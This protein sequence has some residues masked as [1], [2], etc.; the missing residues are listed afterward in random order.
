[1]GLTP[2]NFTQILQSTSTPQKM[3]EELVRSV[4]PSE[5]EET[6]IAFEK[7][8]VKSYKSINDQIAK[9]NAEILALQ[10]RQ[11]RLSQ[12][13]KV[14]RISRL[15]MAHSGASL[16]ALPKPLLG[17]IIALLPLGDVCSFA[18][19][20][21]AANAH[22]VD[23][24]ACDGPRLKSLMQRFSWHGIGRF[25]EMFV[26]P[27]YESKFTLDCTKLM[28]HQL[29]M[30]KKKFPKMEMK[31]EM[32]GKD[33]GEIMK[34]NLPIR[35][36]K[37]SLEQFISQET[38]RNLR[39][40]ELVI[41]PNLS[42]E[43]LQALRA[44]LESQNELEVLSFSALAYTIG[45]SDIL[46]MFNSV[47][48][49]ASLH[50]DCSS[51]RVPEVASFSPALK[52]IILP[53]REV[54]DAYVQ[55]LLT[56]CR[57]LQRLTLHGTGFRRPFVEDEQPV[58]LKYL[59]LHLHNGI[60]TANVA[61][62]LRRCHHLKK[63]SILLSGNSANYVGQIALPA[64]V[65]EVKIHFFGN[66]AVPVGHLLSACKNLRKLERDGTTIAW[67][68]LSETFTLPALEAFTVESNHEAPF[69][70][71]VCPNL[72]K[73]RLSRFSTAD[74]FERFTGNA[75]LE[76]VHLKEVEGN[77]KN[78]IRKLFGEGIR[79]RK[80]KI[81]KCQVHA[82]FMNIKLP[83]RLRSITILNGSNKLST[84]LRGQSPYPRITIE[85]VYWPNP[86]LKAQAEA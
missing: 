72:K 79:L 5:R 62:F 23:L 60:D 4:Q 42:P 68:L 6:L 71:R 59:E 86:P 53:E 22:L 54:N 69:L 74:F 77:R 85:G 8:A 26:N 76:D 31:L 51:L 81:D 10:N 21:K 50:V 45:L 80:L 78:G 61:Q 1:M 37:L 64:S 40:L 35:H 65:Q 38:P 15:Q 44:Q 34:M 28:P 56:R 27:P 49:S 82:P 16:L 67:N 25:L 20:A 19:T 17:K 57:Q 9:L 29:Q 84:V 13:Q 55:Q 12:I 58:E 43:L 36:M 11:A 14:A 30:L 2:A 48:N 39:S 46:Q 75:Q 7:E 47:K 83:P 18:V 66:E 3:V 32:I 73:L 33:M 52:S 63:C 41:E 24:L 70:S